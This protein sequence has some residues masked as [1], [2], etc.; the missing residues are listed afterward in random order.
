[1]DY[2]SGKGWRITGA[3]RGDQFVRNEVDVPTPDDDPIGNI[4][5]VRD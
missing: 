3:S 1:M 2:L 5:H 4:V